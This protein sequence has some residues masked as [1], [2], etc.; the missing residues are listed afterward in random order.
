MNQTVKDLL[1]IICGVLATLLAIVAIAISA[2]LWVLNPSRL[3]PMVEETLNESLNAETHLG[4]AE[5]S[6][7]S[8]FPYLTVDLQDFELTSK[9]LRT[10]PEAKRA[11]LPENADSLVSFSHARAG[12]NLLKA[13]FFNFAIHDANIEGLAV[14]AVSCDS[15]NNFDLT[16]PDDSP[17]VLPTLMWNSITLTDCRGIN[18]FAVTDSTQM[19]AQV[20]IKDASVV[21]TKKSGTYHLALAGDVAVGYAGMEML[22]TSPFSFD[23]DM[24]WNSNEPLTVELFNLKANLIDIPAEAHMLLELENA[25]MLSV[26]EAA[27]GPVRLSSILPKLPEEYTSVLGIKDNDVECAIRVNLKAPYDMAGEEL[28]SLAATLEVPDAYIETLNGRARLDRVRLKA[29]VETDGKNPENNLF[30]L[31]E[32]ILQ[33]KTM[34][35]TVNGTVADFTRDAHVK[36]AVKGNANIGNLVK[37]FAIPLDFVV[38]GKVNANAQVDMRMSDLTPNTFHRMD[39]EGEAHLTDFEYINAIDTISLFTKA[40]DLTFGN[41]DRFIKQTGA[42][43]H[44]LHFSAKVDTLNAT[45]PGIDL[46]IRDGKLGMGTTG[47]I[48]QLMDTT[49]VEP[50]GARIEA[51]RL[52]LRQGDGS[53]VRMARPVVMAQITRYNSEARTPEIHTNITADGALY[54]SPDLMLY[55]NRGK[56]D[57]YAHINKRKPL[58]QQQ[59]DSLA[60]RF[61]AASAKNER[62]EGREYLDVDMGQNIKDLVRRWRLHGTIEAEMG[63]IYTP[64]FPLRNRLA[65]LK[66]EFSLDSLLVHNADYTVGE[67]KMK[68]NGGIRNMRG[69]MM[70]RKNARPLSIT[71]VVNADYI[72]LNQLIKAAGEGMANNATATKISE[73]EYE[74]SVD[75]LNDKASDKAESDSQM[76]AFV[77]PSN[78][79]ADITLRS[80]EVLYSDLKMRRFGG[81]LSIQDAAVSLNNLH[82]FT[83]VGGANFS[84]LYTAPDINHVHL[85]MDMGLKKV[86]LA[87]AIDM[88]PGI[89]SIMPLLES[90]DGIVNADLLASADVDSAM[91][92]VIPSVKAAVK[93]SGDSLVFMDAMTFKKV[94]KMLFFKNKERNVIDHMDVE[95]IIDDSQLQVFPFMF[96]V[97]RY[98]LGV[99]GHNDLDMNFRYHISVLKSPIPFK[100]GINIYGNPDK[101]HFR[102]GGAKYKDASVFESAKILDDTRVNL[103]EEMNKALKSGARKALQSNKLSFNKRP[104]FS[105]LDGKKEDTAKEE[106]LSHEDSIQMKLNGLLDDD[107]KE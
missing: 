29:A 72:D 53:R 44:M 78:V 9:S 17:L 7:W 65:N 82:A 58:T 103:R 13:I 84:A 51:Q 27:V 56:F 68:V 57:L 47:R 54:Y 40:A 16:E 43:K 10:L 1:I 48:S 91:N 36:G 15:V 5:L 98:R 25:P 73:K 8:T 52:T 34:S 28:P 63:G 31:Q 69:M 93:L 41:S 92:V 50:M 39:L 81:N 90:V 88:L 59:R 33:G 76:R 100:F 61:R 106:M 24:K 86:K 101:M 19:S 49:T 105:K 42:T 37:V 89:D 75:A 14:N 97:D 62:I 26:L 2:A 4:R 96:D 79:E 55:L 67:S 30:E 46:G 104:N 21:S 71:F 6:V 60:E 45:M 99:L 87:S 35:L 95:M 107:D 85:D 12:V 20:A 80:K 66:M 77:V 22:K 32:M 83:D 23:G 18:Y 64:M 74:L 102:F 94:A 38:K 11:L 70:G 3:T